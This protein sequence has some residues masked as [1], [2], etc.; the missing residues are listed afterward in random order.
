MNQL[1]KRETNT[2]GLF[3]RGKLEMTGKKSSLERLEIRF[4][5]IKPIVIKEKIEVKSDNN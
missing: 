4:S 5:T 1:P 2:Y 3:M